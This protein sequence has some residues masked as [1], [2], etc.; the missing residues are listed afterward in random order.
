MTCSRC[1]FFL[2]FYQQQQQQQRISHTKGNE[3]IRWKWDSQNKSICFDVLFSYFMYNTIYDILYI[4]LSFNCPMC[5]SKFE[6]NLLPICPFAF[7]RRRRR[8]TNKK[9]NNMSCGELSRVF[10]YY[11]WLGFPFFFFFFEGEVRGYWTVT[12]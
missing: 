12:P 4:P 8:K 9:N 2:F 5:P 11:L 1:F 10:C 3:I 6:K 7:L